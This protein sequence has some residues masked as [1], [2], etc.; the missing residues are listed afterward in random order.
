MNLRQ[1]KTC[2]LVI[3]QTIRCRCDKVEKISWNCKNFGYLSHTDSL[4]TKL[5]VIMK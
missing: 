5:E 1:E 3:E 2:E 4:F